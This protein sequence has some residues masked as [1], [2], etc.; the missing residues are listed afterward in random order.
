VE[1]AGER[2]GPIDSAAGGRDADGRAGTGHDAAEPGGGGHG[3]GG[4]GGGLATFASLRHRNYQYL[5][6]VTVFTSGG[7]WVQHVTLGWLVYELTGSAVLLGLLNALRGV[8]YLICSPWA[9]VV[10]DRVDRRVLLMATQPLLIGG[11]LAIGLLIMLDLIAVW[12]V[13]VF[14]LFMALVW[15]FSTPARQALLPSTVP[16]RDLMNAVAL[17]STAFNSS[18]VLGPAL[19][20]A[21]ILWF[22]AAGNFLVQAAGYA[23]VLWLVYLIQV[24]PGAAAAGRGS[25]LGD[26]KEGLAYIWRTPVVLGLLAAAMVPHVFIIPVYMALMPVFQKDILLVGPDGLGLLLAAPGV[27]GILATLGVASF[28]YRVRRPGLLLIGCLVLMGLSVVAFSQ[29]TSLIPAMLAL[30]AMGVFQLTFMSTN[31]TLLQSTVPDAL[32]GRVT[33]IYIMDQGI[34]PLGALV[35]GVAAEALGAPTTVAAFGLVTALLAGV[36]AWRFPHLRELRA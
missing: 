36:L 31:H 34:A 32:R 17:N 24:P 15:A 6:L 35:A 7:Y 23:V 28:A 3:A 12:H 20:G 16:R 1:A 4:H 8:P 5:F 14:A 27:G 29:M 21:L 9:G 10:S 19:G 25:A 11:A 33:S 2:R 13:M 26:L 30:F 18:K 22:G